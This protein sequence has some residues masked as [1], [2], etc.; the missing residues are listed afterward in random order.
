MPECP[1]HPIDSVLALYRWR[2]ATLGDLKGEADKLPVMLTYVIHDSR[3]MYLRGALTGLWLEDGRVRV[4]FEPPIPDEL[5]ELAK[6]GREGVTPMTLSLTPCD[7]EAL[8][9]KSLMLPIVFQS[10]VFNHPQAKL[11]FKAFG[12]LLQ[13]PSWQCPDTLR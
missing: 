5:R 4:G 1:Q 2:R 6:I 3:S 11:F 7:H 12:E 13:D 8:H 10:G 9:W